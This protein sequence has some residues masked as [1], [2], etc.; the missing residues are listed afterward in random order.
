L[1]NSNL[2]NELKLEWQ[3]KRRKFGA[4]SFIILT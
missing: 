2:K 1:G 3:S 4:D